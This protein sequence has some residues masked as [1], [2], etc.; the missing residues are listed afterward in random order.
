MVLLF[1]LSFFSGSHMVAIFPKSLLKRNRKDLQRRPTTPFKVLKVFWGV[2]VSTLSISDG[3]K[4]VNKVALVAFPTF[5]KI[6]F[7]YCFR[8]SNGIFPTF[9]WMVSEA[10]SKLLLPSLYV[11]T[12]HVRIG[13]IFLFFGGPFQSLDSS[14]V[15]GT[16]P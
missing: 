4:C 11:A 12:C 16:K 1:P 6:C 5:I 9:F 14:N 8:F 7:P 13:C 3:L 2:L 10:L 15:F